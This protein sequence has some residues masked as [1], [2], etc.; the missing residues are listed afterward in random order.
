MGSV[1]AP[2]LTELFCHLIGRDLVHQRPISGRAAQAQTLYRRG[3]QRGWAQRNLGLEFTRLAIKP[4]FNTWTSLLLRGCSDAA[5][6]TCAAP[7]STAAATGSDAA[8]STAA[9][10]PAAAAPLLEVRRRRG[11]SNIQK[12]LLSTWLVIAFFFFLLL[13]QSIFIHSF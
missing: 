13:F 3:D 2:T 7:G 5:G 12:L 9:C 4:R 10:S 1:R 11:N 8:G 6:S